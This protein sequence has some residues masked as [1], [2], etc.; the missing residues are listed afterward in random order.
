ML[1]LVLKRRWRVSPLDSAQLYLPVPHPGTQRLPYI[2]K[3]ILIINLIKQILQIILCKIISDE[4][5]SDTKFL[6]E[7]F[8]QLYIM[9][10]PRYWLYKEIQFQGC[11][12]WDNDPKRN[13]FIESDL[14][15]YFQCS[16]F[17]TKSWNLCSRIMIFKKQF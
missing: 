10:T 9:N 7:K 11:Q 1:Q 15:R 6:E 2:M 12:E 14:L 4:S 13:V 17:H 8:F 16:D 3:D 5:C